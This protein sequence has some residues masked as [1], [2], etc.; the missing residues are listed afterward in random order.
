MKLNSILILLFLILSNKSFCQLTFPKLNTTNYSVLIGMDFYANLS[1]SLD[2]KD[3]LLTGDFGIGGYKLGF[4]TTIPL[5]K[6][7]K[8][9]STIYFGFENLKGKCY[10]IFFPDSSIEFQIKYL[11]IYPQIN[12]D[13]LILG[14]NFSF[15]IETSFSSNLYNLNNIHLEKMAI[16]IEPIIGST[17]WMIIDNNLVQTKLNFNFGFPINNLFL[18]DINLSNFKFNSKIFNANIS[19]QIGFKF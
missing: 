1:I 7:S 9:N 10:R 2:L 3:S 19:L 8:V 14:V 11:Y 13:R 18:N 12:I 16:R 17:L 15:P 6:Y 5:S 4:F